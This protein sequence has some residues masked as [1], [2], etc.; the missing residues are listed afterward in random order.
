MHAPNAIPPATP[1]ALP[2]E[3]KLQGAHL[4]DLLLALPAIGAALQ[5]VPV[6]VTGLLPRHFV[7]L[8]GLPVTFRHSTEGRAHTLHPRFSPGIHRTE[9]WLNALGPDTQAVRVP[10][11]VQGLPEARNLLPHARWALLSTSAD[12]PSKCWPMT[13][14]VEVAEALQTRG[15]Q[16][17]LIGPAKARVAEAIQWPSGV[18]D[19]RGMDTPLTWP[20]LLT[21]AALVVS[22]DTG[23]LHMADALGIPVVGL[24][25]VANPAEYGPFWQRDACVHAPTMDAIH[26]DQVL[27]LVDSHSATRNPQ[28]TP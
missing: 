20:A 4:G 22:L 12:H 1:A 10:I 7:A 3:F 26:A 15:Y 24:Y 18:H 19:L 23:C 5:R 11:P 27:A 25:S 8:R 28:I 9:A 14:W 17:A 6:V 21:R 2:A 16:V 13:R